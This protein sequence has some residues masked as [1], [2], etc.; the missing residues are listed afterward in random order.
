V[1]LCGIIAG[2]S[3]LSAKYFNEV[4]E[5]RN[6]WSRAHSSFLR[7]DLEGVAIFTKSRFENGWYDRMAVDTLFS[8]VD[9]KGDMTAK[10]NGTAKVDKSVSYVHPM[11][12]LLGC[13]PGKNDG[14]DDRVEWR[15]SKIFG[16]NGK[17]LEEEKRLVIFVSSNPKL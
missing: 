5:C 10:E 7:L 15:R 3:T 11:A 4:E 14:L 6:D 16:P 12:D 1:S 13:K 8:T 2:C 9:S 17:A